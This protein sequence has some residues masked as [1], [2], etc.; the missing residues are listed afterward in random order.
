MKL[1]EERFLFDIFGVDAVSSTLGTT[2]VWVVGTEIGDDC[3]VLMERGDVETE[4]S[5]LRSV[6]LCS[7]F[8]VFG[9]EG[10]AS[11]LFSTFAI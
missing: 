2:V 10:A 7:V 9:K 5:T 4:F 8:I 6:S 3:F 11:T 1:E